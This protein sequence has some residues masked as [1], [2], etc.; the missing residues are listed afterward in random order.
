M[1]KRI[2]S[3]ILA[4]ALMFSLAA[5]TGI[6]A[7]AEKY[8]D[9]KYELLDDGT[10]GIYRYYGNDNDAV[11][12]ETIDERPVTMIMLDAFKFNSNINSITIP[13]S[14][15]E[16]HDSAFRGCTKLSKIT[17]GDNIEHIG[18]KAF[19]DTAYYNNSKN[20]EDGVLYLGN[21]LLSGNR[22]S[23]NGY[24]NNGLRD[25]VRGDYTIKDGTTLIAELAFDNCKELTGITVP[26]SISRIGNYVFGN[27]T[28][29]ETI[30]LPD[31]IES[32]G[33]EAFNHTAYYNNTENWENGILYLG[34]YLIQSQLIVFDNGYNATYVLQAE[35]DVIIK[36][37]TKLIAES[38][39][40]S[41][42]KLT[43]VTIPGSIKY[44]D[45]LTFSNCKNLKSIKLTA[46]TE[47][48]DYHAFAYCDSLE[49]VVLPHGLKYINNHAFLKCMN[50]KSIAIP[51]SVSYIGK[52]AF[53]FYTDYD[54]EDDEWY[55]K[56]V[57]N[58]HIN[59]YEDTAGEQYAIDNGFDYTLLSA[60]YGDV[61]YDGKVNMLDVLL[62]RKYI[63]KQPIDL[64]ETL[65]DVTCDD[66]VNMLDVLLIRK[67][68]AK[69]PVTLGPKG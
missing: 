8:G 54:I 21:Y 34:N 27:C 69:Q 55:D 5:V 68:I 19:L 43:G 38:A 23:Y 30:S 47:T 4:V 13:N 37:G 42:D 39:F 35:G 48:I 61:N 59:C 46:G 29:L 32:I 57:P 7:S 64:D 41:N 51:E 24:E 22:Y 63:A 3:M 66:K 50:L 14:V 6:T 67:Y 52:C 60:E 58:F 2:I 31:T 12:P 18:N 49:N 11:I 25:T 33:V 20:W 65:A 26:D 16:I 44:I 36:N 17:I 62:I 28:K 56:P 53:G 15:T 10:V 9:F 45:Q 40:M 1:K